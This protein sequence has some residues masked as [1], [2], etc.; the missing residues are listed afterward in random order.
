[1][2]TAPGKKRAEIERLEAVIDAYG[3][4]RDRWPAVDRLELARLLASDR[5]ARRILVE[6]RALDSVL[7][8]APALSPLRQE[9]LV[10]AIVS[11][12]RAEGRPPLA[13]L[14]TSSRRSIAPG[15]TVRSPQSWS[16]R[17]SAASGTIRS[18]ALLA[19]SLVLGIMAGATFL[20]GELQGTANVSGV[21]YEEA[22]LN[23]LVKDE[24][25]LD[26]IE[27]DLI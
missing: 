2:T 10:R 14:A 15:H 17:P 24:D 4:D 16:K 1:M 22:L 7:D 25:S 5:E 9:A 18:V 23:Q 12:A 19:A 3:G 26:M 6:A 20:S 8:S 27:E 13:G 21:T 11:T